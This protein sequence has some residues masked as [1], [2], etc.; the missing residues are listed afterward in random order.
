MFG[1][2]GDE[3][4][5]VSGLQI[6]LFEAQADGA[7][8]QWLR[9]VTTGE[10]GRFHIATEPGCYVL[11]YVAPP[12][13]HFVLSGS[14]WFSRS[15]CLDAGSYRSVSSVVVAGVSNEPGHLDGQVLDDGVGV[16]GLHVDLFDQDRLYL[17]TRVTGTDGRVRFEVE[18]AC[19]QVTFIAPEGRTFDRSRTRYDTRHICGRA[20][21]A[22]SIPPA[23]LF[24]L[25]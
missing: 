14:P 1:G 12:D 10:E 4:G 18:T 2:V 21:S 17:G 9:S 16:P 3:S 22:V 13:R 19:Y 15:V 11:T 23:V 7:R 25:P 5:P 8:G 6:D 24:P 20:G